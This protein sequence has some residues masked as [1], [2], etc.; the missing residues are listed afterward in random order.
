MYNNSLLSLLQLAD[1]MIPIGGYSHSSGLETY[2]QQ[3]I[4]K[5][6]ASARN[7]VTQMLTL[8]IHYTDAAFVSLAYNAAQQNDW[9]SLLNLDAECTAI[10]L[11]REIRWA[12][13][14]LGMRLIKTF[15]PICSCSMTD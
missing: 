15:Q 13:H 12:S 3:G 6:L 10:K 7:F 14:K 5:D 1:P 2:I 8:N 11:P 4:V 9:E